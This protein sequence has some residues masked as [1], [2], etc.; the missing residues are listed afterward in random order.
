MD[1]SDEEKFHKNHLVLVRCGESELSSK[2]N[3]TGW[4][5]PPLT[6]IGIEQAKD[7]GKE[8]KLS[9][10]SF[11]ICFTSILKRAVNTWN[12]MAEELDMH[13]VP[14]FKMWQLNA[15]HY[16]ALQGR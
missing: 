16:G 2:K 9:N 5:N 14:V 4:M 11:D 7:L 1:M 13:Y 6:Q 3:F 15:R 8:L 12:Y 10:I